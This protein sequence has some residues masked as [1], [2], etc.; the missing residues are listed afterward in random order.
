MAIG[1][2]QVCGMN[3][4]AFDTC[5]GACSVAMRWPSHIEPG[6]GKMTHVLGGAYRY[7]RMQRGHAERLVPMIDEVIADS[8]LGF[9]NIDRIHVTTGPGTFTGMRIGVAAARALALSLNIEAFGF[10]SLMVLERQA[11][12][13]FF[14]EICVAMRGTKYGWTPDGAHDIYAKKDV[15][16]AVNAG[17][18]QIYFQLFGNKHHVPL[19]PPLLLTPGAAV[20]HLRVNETLIAGSG[21]E[22]FCEAASRT[23]RELAPRLLDLQPNASSL[24]GINSDPKVRLPL[25]PLY[26]CPPDAKPQDG[27]SLM[28][29]P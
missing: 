8:P 25:S 2:I 28:R 26:L 20:D 7:E 14:N 16:I 24:L 6:P 1:V 21:A 15:A 22:H 5:F 12:A 18:G 19:T 13:T 11:S 29:A 17:R 3:I 10:S 4:L 27:K 23:G 9:E